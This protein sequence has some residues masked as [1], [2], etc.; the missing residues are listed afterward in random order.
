MNPSVSRGRDEAANPVLDE[1][2]AEITDKLQAGQAVDVETYATNHPDLAEELRRALGT[3][4]CARMSMKPI[5]VRHGC[6]RTSAT[7]D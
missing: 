5:Q 1:L 2:I 7:C 6:F 4:A 3:L